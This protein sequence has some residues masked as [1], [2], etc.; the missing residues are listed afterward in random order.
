RQRR[1]RA[2]RELRVCA[3]GGVG[4]PG[5]PARARGQGQR[6]RAQQDERAVG[7]SAVH[8]VLSAVRRW[9]PSWPRTP[10]ARSRSCGSSGAS[11]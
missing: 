8:G 10:A 6:G 7:K 2:G 9:R 3:A 4:R 1:I 11:H 5:S